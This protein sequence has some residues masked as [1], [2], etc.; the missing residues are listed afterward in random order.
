MIE[1]DFFFSFEQKKNRFLLEFTIQIQFITF[2]GG[3]KLKQ[4]NYILLNKTS[5]YS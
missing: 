2:V 4:E 3:M 1:R 5:V